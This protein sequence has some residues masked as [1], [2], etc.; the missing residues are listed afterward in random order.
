MT[1]AWPAV[2]SVPVAG[3][4]KVSAPFRTPTATDL[5]DG[6]VRY[7]RSTTLNIATLAFS[8]QMSNADFGTF[9]VWVRD[10]LVDGTL[11]FTMPI[12]TGAAFETRTCQFTQ[13]YTDD[14]GSGLGGELVHQVSLSL[15]VQDY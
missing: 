8:I 12:W 15:D 13:P 9:K 7:R 4:L 2:N 10:T 11:P 6:N 1:E 14:P 5:D 3:T